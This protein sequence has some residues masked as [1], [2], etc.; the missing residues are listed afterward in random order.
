MPRYPACFV[1]VPVSFAYLMFSTGVIA[2]VCSTPL[3]S[4]TTVSCLFADGSM[5]ATSWSHVLIGVPL[6][7]TMW[8]PDCS[9]RNAG[10][11]FAVD[12]QVVLFAS[13]ELAG[14]THFA[15]VATVVV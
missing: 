10:A 5:I 12:G 2:T 4:S 15:T 3:R 13:G 9:L 11:S 7:E 1:F 6:T 14:T 8:S